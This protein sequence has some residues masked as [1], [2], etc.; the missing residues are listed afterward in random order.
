MFLTKRHR[1]L[2][3]LPPED[4]AP[5]TPPPGRP[6]RCCDKAVSTFCTCGARGWKCPVHDVSGQECGPSHD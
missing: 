4:E 2:L 5:S 1:K 3:G 6:P